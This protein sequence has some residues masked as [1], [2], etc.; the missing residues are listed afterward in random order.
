[1]KQR[2]K[3][4]DVYRLVGQIHPLLVIAKQIVVMGLVMVHRLGH[5]MVGGDIA[6]IVEQQVS[7]D[8][9]VYSIVYSRYIPL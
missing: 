8:D 3:L 5:L 9:C 1:M 7:D 2:S 6:G 4:R